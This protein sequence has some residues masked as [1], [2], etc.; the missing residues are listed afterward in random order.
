MRLSSP[1]I[2]PT[3]V[4]TLLS[5]YQEEDTTHPAQQIVDAVIMYQIL[6]LQGL[7]K[8]VYI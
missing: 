3:K 7:K 2:R 6:I 1:D 5:Q 8:F 4:V